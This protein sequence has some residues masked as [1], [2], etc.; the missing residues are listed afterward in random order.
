MLYYESFTVG[1]TSGRVSSGSE[2]SAPGGLSEGDLRQQHRGFRVQIRA[3]GLKERARVIFDVMMVDQSTVDLDGKLVEDVWNDIIGNYR[4]IQTLIEDT[5][6]CELFSQ[7]LN[8]GNDVISDEEDGHDEVKAVRS[9]REI[10][11]EDKKVVYKPQVKGGSE[12]V[13]GL[14][15]HSYMDKFNEEVVLKA[16]ISL[17]KSQR[18]L[19]IQTE[20]VLSR[21]NYEFEIDLAKFIS[22]QYLKGFLESDESIKKFKEDYIRVLFDNYS[23]V[24]PRDSENPI[25]FEPDL[26]SSMKSVFFKEFNYDLSKIDIEDFAVINQIQ[27]KYNIDF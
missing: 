11:K 21:K 23:A 17:A 3:M 7:F 2:A 15:T 27:D 19:K 8:K 18:I 25:V 12:R 20:E 9:P 10:W 13:V 1:G 14:F 6:A 4:N 26:E 16:E 5:M 24:A 22:E